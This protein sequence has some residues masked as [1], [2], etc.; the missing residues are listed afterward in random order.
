MKVKFWKSFGTIIGD[1]STTI[2]NVEYIHQHSDGNVTIYHGS[3]YKVYR[4]D[5]DFDYYTVC[6]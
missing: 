5:V 1:S 2:E 4:K 3:E 6:Q